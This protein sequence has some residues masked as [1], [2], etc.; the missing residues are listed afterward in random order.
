MIILDL[1]VLKR[2][3]PHR[4]LACEVMAIRVLVPSSIGTGIRHLVVEKA[5]VVQYMA[6]SGSSSGT[7]EMG[8]FA[9]GKNVVEPRAV[10]TVAVF[11]VFILR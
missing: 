8:G 2:E 3:V 1:L 6:P 11:F 5:M 4:A 10:G 7:E 9:V